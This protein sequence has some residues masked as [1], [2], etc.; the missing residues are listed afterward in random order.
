MSFNCNIDGTKAEM[1]NPFGL[2]GHIGDKFG[3]RRQVQE[4]FN[5][6]DSFSLTFERKWILEVYFLKRSI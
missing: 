3:L 1:G 4:L 6:K 2:A 5:H